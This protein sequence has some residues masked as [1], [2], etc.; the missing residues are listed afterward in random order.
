M[1]TSLQISSL[2]FSL[3]DSG[4]KFLVKT[5]FQILPPSFSER[6]R[7]NFTPDFSSFS[8]G[9][10]EGNK[11]LLQLDSKF[12]L[13]FFLRRAEKRPSQLH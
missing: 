8:P 3:G 7:G 2:S 9:N 13:L 5:S 4:G 1:K 11:S 10:P 12:S 6:A